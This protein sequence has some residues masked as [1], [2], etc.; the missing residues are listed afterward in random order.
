MSLAMAKIYIFFFKISMISRCR[1]SGQIEFKIQVRF[2]HFVSLC[3]C[4]CATLNARSQMQQQQ[5][6]KNKS[7]HNSKSFSI[8]NWT[9]RMTFHWKRSGH[10]TTNIYSTLSG[11]LSGM[12]PSVR[13]CVSVT[14]KTCWGFFLCVC[15]FSPFP[16]PLISPGIHTHP[17]WLIRDTLDGNHWHLFIFMFNQVKWLTGVVDDFQ[18]F[19]WQSQLFCLFFFFLENFK[20]TCRFFFINHRRLMT[21]THRGGKWEFT[22]KS[23]INEGL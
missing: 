7:N 17:I 3:V 16:L 2:C 18:G 21:I 6:K 9:E 20:V 15:L 10:F 22:G 23:T 1:L 12:H 8:Y 11:K 14:F 5:K 13:V 4:V 19:S